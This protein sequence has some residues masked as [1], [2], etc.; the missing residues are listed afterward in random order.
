MSKRIHLMPAIGF[1]K[2]FKHSHLSI[3]QSRTTLRLN[4]GAKTDHMLDFEL[5]LAPTVTG[6]MRG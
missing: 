5:G 6:Y 3:L 4:Y 1:C 2:T